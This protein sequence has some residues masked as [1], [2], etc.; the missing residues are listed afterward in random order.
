MWYNVLEQY[1]FKGVLN[2]YQKY[3]PQNDWVFF[4]HG[5]ILIKLIDGTKCYNMS[6]KCQSNLIHVSMYIHW[7]AYIMYHLYWAYEWSKCRPSNLVSIETLTA[8]GTFRSAQNYLKLGS[9]ATYKRQ[10]EHQN[11][12]TTLIVYRENMGY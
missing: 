3:V 1:L 5:K 10:H 2:L 7:I 11:Y 4:S 6:C 9:L 12:E 8:V